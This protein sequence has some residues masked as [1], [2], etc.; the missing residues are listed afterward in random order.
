[1]LTY[2]QVSSMISRSLQEHLDR[3][4]PYFLRDIYISVS[5][6]RGSDLFDSELEFL[7]LHE[8]AFIFDDENLSK[9]INIQ[10][11]MAWTLYG[12]RAA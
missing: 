4:D 11:K 7:W 3:E 6:T 10:N 9:L 12:G 2:D 5:R 1:M 8:M